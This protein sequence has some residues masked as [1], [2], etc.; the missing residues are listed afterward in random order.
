MQQKKLEEEVRQYDATLEQQKQQA[1]KAAAGRSSGG[2]S[3]SK[4]KTSTDFEISSVSSP[5]SFSS[6]TAT[7]WY[8]KNASNLK[9]YSQL[10]NAIASGLKSGSI[11]QNDADKIFK[12]YGIN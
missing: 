6:K 4:T 8:V 9:T 10:N 11:T 5:A 2:S 3:R 1:A 7:K 12:S